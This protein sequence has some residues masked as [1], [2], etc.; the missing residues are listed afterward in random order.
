MRSRRA[1]EAEP[2]KGRIRLVDSLRGLAALI[3]VVHHARTLFP[4]TLRPSAPTTGVFWLIEQVSRLNTEAVLLF[5]VLS[6]FSIRLSIEPRGLAD[7]RELAHYALRRL[8]RILP[9]YW[10]ALLVSYLLAT[11][12]APLSAVATSWSTLL[13]N[14]LFVQ[15][16]VGVPGAWVLPYAGDGP[17]WSLS[18][19]VFYYAAFAWLAWSI[20]D[21]RVRLAVVFM[22]T[23]SALLW[24]VWWPCPWSLF[25]AS[26]LIWYSGVELAQFY[27]SG[28][29]IVRWS[30][31]AACAVLLTSTQAG[32]HGTTFYGLWIASL[33]WLC[34]ALVISLRGRLVGLARW[35]EWP[36]LAPLGRVGDLSYALYL[37]H[38]P[39]LRAAV[40]A[41]GDNMAALAI[42]VTISFMLAHVTERAAL[43]LARASL[44]SA[45][46][47]RDSRAFSAAAADHH[48]LEGAPRRPR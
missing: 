10:F 9:P 3:V 35:L 15:T 12:F 43:A 31:L 32:A 48:R 4:H 41:L 30:L 20:A 45:R 23:S 1:Y 36:L 6:G 38:V 14:L 8:L 28:R 25:L 26:S 19:E 40:A 46:A 29:S 11:W 21:L 22:A 33:F 7:R 47:P 44:A 34:G 16:A 5:F 27:L 17:L 39:V 18:F 37:L 2:G 24:N 13:G 42:A